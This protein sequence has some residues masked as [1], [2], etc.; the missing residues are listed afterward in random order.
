MDMTH[1]Q[2]HYAQ[3]LSS[4][5]APGDKWLDIGCGHQ[6]LP[7]WVMNQNQQCE[8]ASRASLL[9]GTDL[10]GS[11]L[12]HP[13]LDARV[14]G[15]GEQLP[16]AEETFDLLTANM[17]F[18]H[19]ADP[20]QVLQEARRV[21]KRGGRLLFHTPNYHNYLVA[22]ASLIPDFV[23]RRVIWLLEGRHEKDVF[24]TLYRFNTVRRIRQVARECGLEVEHLA[25][26]VSGG[27]FYVLGP[28]AWVECLWLKLVTVLG[29]GRFDAGLVVV[30]KRPP[31]AEK[32][33][34]REMAMEGIPV[35]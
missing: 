10:D 20:A 13:L 4:L 35:S 25:T 21:L 17:V 7:S 28:V 5:V 3:A 29:R 19:V 23:K 32:D 34:V 24:P 15:I 9:V 26:H 1:A 16:F 11:I 31:A 18:E 2:K 22:V 6:I 30:L 14:V 33:D 12:E 8:L 27:E